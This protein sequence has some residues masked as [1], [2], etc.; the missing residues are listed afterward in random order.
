MP[1]LRVASPVPPPPLFFF[2]SGRFARRREDGIGGWLNL[3]IVA[4]AVDVGFA[5]MAVCLYG[6]WPCAVLELPAVSSELGAVVFG[7]V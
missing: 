7:G 2:L 1:P 5:F 3:Y 6:F 4:V